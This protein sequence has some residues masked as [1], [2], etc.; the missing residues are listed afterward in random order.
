MGYSPWMR[1]ELRTRWLGRHLHSDFAS[2]KS[3]LQE[4]FT[5]VIVSHVTC[6]SS[7][8]LTLT[9]R[10]PLVCAI[11]SVP[12]KMLAFRTSF[13]SV[14]VVNDPILRKLTLESNSQQFNA[15]TMS[16]CAGQRRWA[17]PPFSRPYAITLPFK[18]H[19]ARVSRQETSLCHKECYQ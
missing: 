2:C 9:A 3:T 5:Y 13:G 19:K 12:V 11:S 6:V 18:S 17:N 8:V 1:V 7:P 16:S 15:T 14:W 4:K 10:F